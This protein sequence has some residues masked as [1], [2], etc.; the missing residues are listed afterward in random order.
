MADPAPPL[1]MDEPSAVRGEVVV[2][3]CLDD[4]GLINS[5]PLLGELPREEDDSEL[6]CGIFKDLLSET[7]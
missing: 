6:G 4:E 3:G 7:G 2:E 5:K 1:P